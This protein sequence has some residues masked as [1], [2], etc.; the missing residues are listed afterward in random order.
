M[1]DFRALKIWEKG[2]D[3]VDISYDV[4]AL[5]PDS[6]RYGL[7]SQMGRASISIPTNIA[8][9]CARRSTK[10][11]IQFLETS[12]GSTFELQTQAMVV[13][14]KFPQVSPELI[15]KLLSQLDEERRMLVTFIS[16]QYGSLDN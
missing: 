7:K 15:D 16:N 5:L 10:H 2:M 1:R 11:F 9:G 13:Q 6:E 12:L 3:V 14:R 4:I 8:E